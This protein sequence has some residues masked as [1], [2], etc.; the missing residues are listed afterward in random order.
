MFN[1]KGN[2]FL[3]VAIGLIVLIILL[4]ATTV[5]K[6]ECRND[7]DCKEDYYCGSDF[8]CHEPKIIEKIIVQNNLLIPSI[9]LA[10]GLIIAALIIRYI[11]IH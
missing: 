9:I 10:I 11:K 2:V 4:F 1:K 8:E 5:F 6:K 3:I 7:A